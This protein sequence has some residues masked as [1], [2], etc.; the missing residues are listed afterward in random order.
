MNM[1]KQQ[2]GKRTYVKNIAEPGI[3]I[4]MKN[5]R[6]NYLIFVVENIQNIKEYYN[7]I[8]FIK[9]LKNLYLNYD[10]SSK[11]LDKCEELIEDLDIED[12]EQTDTPTQSIDAKTRPNT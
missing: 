1:I 3:N 8:K 11:K 9:V 12:N 5:V 2:E 7:I 10:K 4:K 6:G